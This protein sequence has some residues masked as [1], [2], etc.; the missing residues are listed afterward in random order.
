MVGPQP[1]TWRH[2]PLM[3]SAVVDTPPS[4]V[5]RGALP[6]APSG[7]TLVPSISDTSWAA[8]GGSVQLDLLAALAHALADRYMVGRELGRGGMAVVCAAR[9]LRDGREVAI[10]LLYP[11][12]ARAVGGERFLREIQILSRLSHPNILPLL[13]SGAIELLPG[14]PVPWYTMPLAAGET[15][16]A[17][18]GRDGALPLPIALGY[19]RDLCA[20]LTHAHQQG[21]VH[22]DIKPE[23]ILLIDGQ[24]VLADFG[25]ARAVTVAGGEGLSSTGIV[26]GTPAYMSPEQ[27]V[28]SRQ[29]DGRSDL[30]SLGVVLYE[31]LAGHPPFTGSTPQAVSAR[32]QFESPPPIEV[33]RPGLPAGIPALL[34]RALAKVA[35][36][37]W[38]GA[39]E[40]SEA[41]REAS[42]RAPSSPV[43]SHSRRWGLIALLVALL[44]T[45]SLV[46][47]QAF[48][49]S[50]VDPSRYVVLPFRLKGPGQ[51]T[52]LNGGDC[53]ALITDILTR[54]PDHRLVSSLTT[55][56]ALA[57]IQGPLSPA[58]AFAVARRLGAGR[59]VWGEVTESADT[60]RVTGVLYDVA[61]GTELEN[62]SIRLPL[63]TT[64]ATLAARFAELTYSLV[65]PGQPAPETASDVLAAK[66]MDSWKLYSTGDSALN[67]WNLPLAQRKYREALI[68]DP[69]YPNANLK[70]AQI[71]EWLDT[72]AAEWHSYAKH[73]FE[74]KERLNASNR[75][76]AT[77]LLSIAQERYPEACRAYRALLAGDSLS[78]QG[79]F[80]LGQCLTRDNIVSSD[81]ASTSGWRFRSSYREAVGAYRRGLTLVPATHL[82][83][84]G[85]SLRTLA[86]RLGATPQT[87]RLGRVRRGDPASYAAFPSLDHDTLAFVP[88][89]IEQVIS[90]QSVPETWMAAIQHN[91][92]TLLAIT[93]VWFNTYHTT[94]SA[95]ISQAEALE[96]AGRLESPSSLEGAL[97][98][99]QLLRMNPGELSVELAARE[100]RLLVK[101]RRYSLA[102]LVA[103]STLAIAPRTP[104]QGVLQ[105]GLAGLIGRVDRSASLIGEY[106]GRTFYSQS[107]ELLEVPENVSREA[108]RLLGYAAFGEPAESLLAIRSRLSALVRTSVV[109]S[110][111]SSTL[112]G[113]VFQASL[114]SYPT[115]GPPATGSFRLARAQGLLTAGD[116]SGARKLLAAIGAARPQGVVGLVSPDIALLEARLWLLAGDTLAASRGLSLMLDSLDRL[117]TDFMESSS[118]AAAIG[119]AAQ[120]QIALS[121]R[122]TAAKPSG[123]ELL[124][125]R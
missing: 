116:T 113:L 21:I 120:L 11:D 46:V 49:P 59:L 61:T 28:G 17:R 39:A 24:A 100:V 56:G 54:I 112:A 95:A 101:L 69:D 80:G 2:H 52:L 26:V 98:I 29:L 107:G 37:R 22:R 60:V 96:L 76:I 14:L 68:L 10:K 13:D 82:A 87:L 23:N 33:V 121:P 18:L 16:R 94:V 50:E 4:L 123:P 115:L 34:E 92:E 31:M 111:R 79:W 20:A 99:T 117:G 51:P 71:N 58:A 27:S 5:R 42:D 125:L 75:L 84:G 104:E 7:C 119:R 38:M 88:Q 90:G 103:E 12:L 48:S 106:G 89:P 36:D 70:L 122:H 3:P 25:I 108:N 53:E 85:G 47:P 73:A 15:L 57:A 40:L 86:A 41:L 72:P 114:L 105:S 91:R 83:Y 97:G 64:V 110:Q 74:A 124:W 1:V 8:D 118:Q 102:R 67:A 77:A 9:D 66:S 55:G 30:Y 45:G 93:S 32:H 63:S 62:H 44:G 35:A 78:F 19:A 65:L 81:S 6:R 109:N 43:S